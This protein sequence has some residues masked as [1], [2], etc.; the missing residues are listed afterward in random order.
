MGKD[1]MLNGIVLGSWVFNGDS[2]CLPNIDEH[3]QGT[4]GE[5]LSL[6]RENVTI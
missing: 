1:G 2:G 6:H 4:G 5:L 3:Q